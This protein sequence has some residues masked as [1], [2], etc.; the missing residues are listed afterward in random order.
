MFSWTWARAHTHIQQIQ[1]FDSLSKAINQAKPNCHSVHYYYRGTTNRIAH[2]HWL[3]MIW[4]EENRIF[5][6]SN[7]KKTRKIPHKICLPHSK[8]LWM[9]AHTQIILCILL[10]Y[11]QN[12]LYLTAMGRCLHIN[13]SSRSIA[14]MYGIGVEKHLEME[15]IKWTNLYDSTCCYSYKCAKLASRASWW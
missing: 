14:V 5:S 4:F 7:K 2:T 12:R 10:F 13:E 11:I 3:Q 6:T 1:Q 15:V 9:E 8:D